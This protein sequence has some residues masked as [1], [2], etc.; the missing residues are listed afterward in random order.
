M[1]RNYQKYYRDHF[2]RIIQ[3]VSTLMPQQTLT[4][5]QELLRA[6]IKCSKQHE[7]MHIIF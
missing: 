5:G 4:G 3:M 1:F 2:K 7:N 6:Q